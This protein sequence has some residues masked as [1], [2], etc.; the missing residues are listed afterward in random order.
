MSRDHNRSVVDV[1]TEDTPAG[2]IWRGLRTFLDTDRFLNLGYATHTS[3]YLIGSPQ[4]ALVHRVADELDIDPTP[5]TPRLLDV[6]CGRGGPAIEFQSALGVDCVGIDLVPFNVRLA[7]ANAYELGRKPGF[8]LG[9]AESLPFTSSSFEH[10]TAID[11]LVYIDRPSSVLSELVR[12]V[13]GEIVITDLIVRDDISIDPASLARFER[14]WG[15]APLRTE[16]DLRRSIREAGATIDRHYDLSPQS[17]DRF[18]QWSG[19]YL[20]LARGPT[21]PVIRG[22]LERLGLDPSTATDQIEAA[23]EALPALKHVLFRLD[24][25]G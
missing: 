19:R 2:S 23:H 10:A 3:A 17:V 16:G 13:D 11:M 20:R 8:L 12:V 9:T 22:S 21:A 15:L 25:D 14:A 7:R 5:P 4:R 6:G 1:F 24:P 18:R